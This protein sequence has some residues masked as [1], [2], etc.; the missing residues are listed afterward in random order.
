MTYI[1]DDRSVTS[2]RF[3][4]SDPFTISFCCRYS[5]ETVH[6]SFPAPKE[7]GGMLWM[8]SSNS[9]KMGLVEGARHADRLTLVLGSGGFVTAAV[10][11]TGWTTEREIDINY[12]MSSLIPTL[13]CPQSQFIEIPSYLTQDVF[14]PNQSDRGPSDDQPPRRYLS[15]SKEAS[16]ACRILNYGD[17]FSAIGINKS[18]E[19]WVHASQMTG[20]ETSKEIWESYQENGSRAH[21]REILQAGL[22]FH[23]ERPLFAKMM[24]SNSLLIPL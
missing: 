4:S 6:I 17:I 10:H 21:S 20:R 19:V 7:G 13:R 15:L 22:G 18:G 1:R 3:W 23:P 12:T 24:V 9:L 16:N 11:I 5:S 2:P 14:P 8:A